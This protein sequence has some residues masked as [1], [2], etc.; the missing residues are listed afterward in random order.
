MKNGKGKTFM[1]RQNIIRSLIRVMSDLMMEAVS[2]SES[3]ENFTRLHGTTSQKT[4]T[5]ILI[6]VRT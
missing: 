4:A 6:A 5:F 2:A 1:K 3:L